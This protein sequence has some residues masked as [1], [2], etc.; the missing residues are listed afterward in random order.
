MKSISK[1]IL[2]IMAAAFMLIMAAGCSAASSKESIEELKKHE[3]FMLVIRSTP[4]MEM[5]EE[6][7]KRASHKIGVT[8]SGNAYN[9][10]P[11]NAEYL[12]MSDEDYMKVY[13]FCVTSVAKNKFANYKENV[14][15]GTT[16][17]FTYYDTDGNE[18]LIY[19]GYCYQNKEL[20]VI[21]D[22]IG[23]YQ[24]E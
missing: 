10:N 21:I 12:P 22:I 9:P 17:S 23:K 8:Y 18:H 20:K 13:N 7:F 19:S 14:D 3:G 16:Y 24:L 6:E 2:T 15:D 5:T 1:L 4:Q 11:V